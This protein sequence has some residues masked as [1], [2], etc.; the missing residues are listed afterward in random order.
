MKKDILSREDVFELVSRFYSKV[1]KDELLAPFFTTIKYWDEHLEQL[2][3]F[4]ESSLFLKTKYFGDPLTAH[5]KLDKTHG[6]RIEQ[7][8]FG[9]WMNL[10][11]DTV[12]ELYE[13][14]Y[15]QMAKNR[16]RKMS[17]F[18]YMKI[19]EARQE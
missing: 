4:W 15:A 7:K 14:E 16:A 10:W 13:G 5:V 18:L 3:T 19:F 2:T 9:Q 6:N 12:D 11:Y 17:T 8:H 1:R